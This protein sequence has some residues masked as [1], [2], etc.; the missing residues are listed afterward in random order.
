MYLMGVLC[1]IHPNF[2]YEIHRTLLCK[3]Y[4]TIIKLLKDA[5]EAIPTKASNTFS[6]HTVLDWNDLVRDSHQAA[7]ES[8][9]I[10]RSAGGP[11]HGPLSDVMKIRR[12]H[13]KSN[14]RL[15]EKRLN[16]LQLSDLL[17]SYAIMTSKTSR[18]T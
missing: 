14:K 11:R 8:F 12:A 4:N 18:R 9:L 15:C 10:W 2:N 1:C 6:K 17:L 5:A 3:L 16:C 13:F 7:R